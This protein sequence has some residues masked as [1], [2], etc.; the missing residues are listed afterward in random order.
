M[1]N[2]LQGEA[3]PARAD[4]THAGAHDPAD[5]PLVLALDT[6][7]DVR[8][9]A[10][11]R[12]GRTLALASEPAGAKG[13]SLVLSQIDAA[14]RAAGVAFADVGLFAVATGPGSFTGLRAGLATV[15]AFAATTNLRAAGVPTLHAVACAAGPSACTIAAIPA[16][17]GELFAQFLRIGADGNVEELTAPAH[18][19]PASLVEQARDFSADAKWVGGGAVAHKDSIHEAAERAGYGWRELTPLEAHEE[20]AHAPGWSLIAPFDSYA[21]Q[22]ARLGLLDWGKGTTVDAGSLRALYVRPSDAELNE[23]C[24]A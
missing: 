16:G 21:E 14:L 2:T 5:S 10:V 19:K 7:T 9:V 1:S 11:V 4:T 23:R 17:R 22:I 8:S 24:R 20:R 15:K 13:A 6:A 18:I 12:G 3:P